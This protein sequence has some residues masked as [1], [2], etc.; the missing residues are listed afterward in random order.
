MDLYKFWDLPVV[1]CHV[2]FWDYRTEGNMIGIKD[3]CR[4]DRIN[5]LSIYDRA[6]V[7]QNPECMYLKAKHPESFYAFGALDYS[8]IFSGL[9][10]ADPSLTKQVDDM[11]EMGLDGVKMVEGK[12]TER[13]TI[14]IRFDDD[15]YRDYFAHLESRGFPLLFHVNDPEEFWDP[16]KAPGWAKEQ[17]WFYDSTYPT[18]EQLYDEVERVLERCPG[19]KVIFAHFYFVSGD[20]EMASGFLD[21]NK[22]ACLDLTPGIE[23]FYNFTA[24]RDEWREFFIRYQD[25]IVYGTDIGGGQTIAEATSRAWIVRNFLETDEE[26]LVPKESDSLLGGPEIPFRGLDLPKAALEKIYAGNF[27]RLAGPKPRKLDLDKA[28]AECKRI[29]K[30][31]SGNGVKPED[32]G[33]STIT[34]ILAASR[35]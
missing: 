30:I 31:A 2:H 10:R 33:A 21:R 17:G 11:I 12:P 28:L 22:S 35:K 19:L 29:A 20:V 18:K 7:N 26:F 4:F 25:R 27:E 32:N 5:A 3:A 23:M 16:Q 6:K 14:P 34:S 15:F 8:A 1:D 9:K 24:R 13:K